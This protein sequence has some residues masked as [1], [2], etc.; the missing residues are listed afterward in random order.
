MVNN[1]CTAYFTV[2]QVITYDFVKG[3]IETLRYF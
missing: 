1:S 2:V 3:N